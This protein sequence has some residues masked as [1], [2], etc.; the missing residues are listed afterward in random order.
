MLQVL[1]TPAKFS[2]AVSSVSYA[3][4]RGCGTDAV[5]SPKEAVMYAYNNVEKKKGL[6]KPKHT[7]EEQINYMK[8][9]SYE[10]AYKGLP[11]YK[12]YKRNVRGQMITQSKPRLVCIDTEGKFRLNNA[13]P[14][15]RDEYLFFD[16][17]NPSLIEQFLAP[18][19]DKPIHLLKSGLC[20][21]QYH[22]LQAQLLKA[23]ENGTLTFD[24][25]FRN[26]DYKQWYAAYDGKDHQEVERGTNKLWEIHP[27]PLVDFPTFKRDFGNNWDQW[28]LRHDEF[29]R[30]A[31]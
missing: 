31:K 20:R 16:Y 12:W 25:P 7:I 11:V 6:L 2:R 19:T 24:V 22:Q 30:K 5:E 1:R 17:R 15:C 26:F 4:F 8:S 29:A 10:E 23:Q 28:W 9:K 27:D 21:E 18:G 14:V 13:C 3:A